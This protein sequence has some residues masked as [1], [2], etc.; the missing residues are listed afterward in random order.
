MANSL[1]HGHAHSR[2]HT[3]TSTARLDEVIKST[4]RRVN[5]IEHVIIPKIERTLAYII[6]ELDEAEREE[7]F[8]LKKIQ[9]KK[10]KIREEKIAMLEVEYFD[11]AIC[12]DPCPPIW[13]PSVILAERV[14]FGL[15]S[16][17]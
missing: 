1:A 9:A 2:A 4:K 5:A 3:H 10:A 16:R 12:N 8:R 7:F 15:H 11:M 14:P 17:S 6:S 13:L